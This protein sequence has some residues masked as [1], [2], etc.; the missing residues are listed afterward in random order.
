MATL[1]IPTPLRKF[2]NNEAR[3]QSAG[4]SVKSVINDL[5]TTFDGLKPHLLDG[6]GNIRSFVK[7]YLEDEDIQSLDNEQTEVNQDSI[8][9]IIP[10]I[11][12]GAI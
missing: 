3:F 11:A 5:I 4:G 7:V 9:S 8:I 10:A 6:D 12:G 1:L 2:T